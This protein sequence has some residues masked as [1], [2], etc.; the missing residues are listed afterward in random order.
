MRYNAS[1][2]NGGIMSLSNLTP[3]ESPRDA[4]RSLQHLGPAILGFAYFAIQFVF[5]GW[6]GFGYFGD[7]L[8]YLACA[9]RPA[10]GYVDHPPFSVLI[11]HG[12]VSV[13][14]DSIPVLR[15]LPAAAGG[16]TVLIT[17]LIARRLGGDALAAIIASL[18]SMAAPVLMVLFGFYSM[19]SFEVLLWTT[20]TYVAA[21][22]L[23]EERPQLWIVAGF[24]AGFGL[25][26]KHTMGAYGLAFFAGLLLTPQRKHFRSPWLW[27]GGLIAGLLILPNVFWQSANGWPSVEFYRSADAQKNLYNPAWK[28]VLDQILSQ[29]PASVIVWVPGLLF[30]FRTKPTAKVRVFAW[31]YL[32]LLALL[33]SANSSRP[34]RIAAAYPVLFAAGACAWTSLKPRWVSYGAV[35]VLIVGG[36]V[37][38][39]AGLPVLPAEKLAA[40]AERIGVIPQ[41]EKGKAVSLPMWFGNRFGWEDLHESVRTVY[42]SLPVGERLSTVVLTRSYAQAGAI[43][44]FSR[45]SLRAISGHNNYYLWGPG[46]QPVTAIIAVGV[47][48]QT[49]E[50]LFGDVQPAG[51]YSRRFTND[52][53]TP[54]YLCRKPRSP[55]QEIWA[56]LKWYI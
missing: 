23:I 32:I 36:G 8:Y 43:E 44:R 30:L 9:A 2:L 39:P 38:A 35:I 41:I 16:F 29:N 7:E 5:N 46:D 34:D 25:E 51:S 10:L 37:F 55:L 12:L 20:F 48:R 6:H 15:F 1:T 3:V 13:A 56:R 50:G 17:G 21:T 4:R 22:A 28:V 47:S 52:Q 42:E 18:C 33:M 19:N 31:A 49:L 24:L 14:G 54:I 45:G 26:N 27:A 11:L 40:Y 53:N